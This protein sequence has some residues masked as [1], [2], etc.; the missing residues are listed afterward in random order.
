MSITITNVGIDGG[1]NVVFDNAPTW[2]STSP[3]PDATN[4]TIYSYQLVAT[5]IDPGDSL[6]YTIMSGALP[7]NLTINTSGLISGTP[8]V[9]GVF[10]FVA[11]ATDSFG[12]YR[13]LSFQLTV[14]GAGSFILLENGGH[15]LQENGSKISLE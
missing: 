9:E 13:E 15:L 3:L 1:V 6:S 7:N 4:G 2:T 5:D 14:N 8:N 11:R 12:L 10:N